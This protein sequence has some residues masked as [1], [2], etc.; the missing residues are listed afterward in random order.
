VVVAEVAVEE[1]VAVVSD[2][3]DLE[4]V[5]IMVDHLHL[6]THQVGAGVR[7]VT[8]WFSMHLPLVENRIEEERGVGTDIER[9]ITTIEAHMIGRIGTGGKEIEGDRGRGVR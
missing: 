5:Q 7:M 2:R 6:T 1:A 9:G 3:W 8:I 4:G